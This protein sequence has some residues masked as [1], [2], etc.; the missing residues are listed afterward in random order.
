MFYYIQCFVEWLLWAIL[1]TVALFPQYLKIKET[2]KPKI[3]LRA[4][5]LWFIMMIAMLPI[6]KQHV[7]EEKSHDQASVEIK[8]S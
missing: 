8:N 3:I 1:F 6:H 7:I 4:G 2:D 5:I